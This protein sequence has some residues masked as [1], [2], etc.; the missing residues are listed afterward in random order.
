M[1]LSLD[2][3]R[4]VH[5]NV[6]THSSAQWTAQQIVEAFPFDSAPRFLMRDRDG[7]YGEAFQRRIKNLGIEE[8]VSAPRSLW[9][10]PYVERLI[11]TIR[12][13]LLDHVIVLNE[14]HLKRL[15]AG[16]LDYHHSSRTHQSLDGNA[17]RPREVEPPETGQ[18][19]AIPQVGG[20]HHRYTRR[21]A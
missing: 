6:T 19:V 3:R 17:P 12:R 21:A 10:N 18:V 7:I 14:A 1:V 4:A 13:E 20:L 2:R 15:L 5:F 11:G 16:Y 8:V 9:Q